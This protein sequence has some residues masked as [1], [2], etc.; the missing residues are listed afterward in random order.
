MWTCH[1]Q[2]DF[3]FEQKFFFKEKSVLQ[4]HNFWK[5]NEKW[6]YLSWKCK[7]RQSD[8]NYR[9]QQQKIPARA[10]AR[11]AYAYL[12]VQAQWS[13][14]HAMTTR[15][16]SIPM[17]GSLSHASCMS[18][19]HKTKQGLETRSRQGNHI[20]PQFGP[21]V[22]AL[23]VLMSSQV[24][25]ATPHIVGL[26]PSVIYRALHLSVERDKISRRK[27]NETQLAKVKSK[28]APLT[29]RFQLPQRTQPAL[30]HL[31]SA[32]VGLFMCASHN[33]SCWSLVCSSPFSFASLNAHKCPCLLVDPWFLE[34]D[35]LLRS[36]FLR[37]AEWLWFP[38]Q[39]IPH[40]AQFQKSTDTW[41]SQGCFSCSPFDSTSP[42]HTLCCHRVFALSRFFTAS[43]ILF[44]DLFREAIVDEGTL[45]CRSLYTVRAP[46]H[47]WVNSPRPKKSNSN[48]VND[49]IK[50][51]DSELSKKNGGIIRPKGICFRNIL[52][53]FIRRVWGS[54][55]IFLKKIISRLL[56]SCLVSLSVFFLCLLSL[57]D[58]VVVVVV[59]CV[60]VVVVVVCACGVGE[61][62]PCV[63]SKLP[64]VYR[65]PAH[66]W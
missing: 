50:R 40:D 34:I 33:A 49:W 12:G 56:L 52:S 22:A 32:A 2:I 63:H 24:F 30:P 64:G 15:L 6:K 47:F 8:N 55:N 3:F 46:T 14:V 11:S 1:C 48:H 27:Q 37:S 23:A 9:L 65:H 5:S 35:R 60:Y 62:S 58:V 36:F 54:W 39:P 16:T 66:M 28:K 45:L 26:I 38:C 4:I 44:L 21:G 57:R 51:S 18:S 19:Q 61:N 7:Y 43:G 41:F 53:W 10:V 59:S 25:Q 29:F 20:R 31:P 42:V 17:L 13:N